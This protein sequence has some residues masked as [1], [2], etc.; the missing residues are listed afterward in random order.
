MPAGEDQGFEYPERLLRYPSALMF[1]LMREAFRLGQERSARATSDAEG[2]RFPHFATL[3]CLEEFGPASQR[4]IS[5][6]LRFDPSDLVAFVDWLEEAGLVVRRRDRRDRRRYAVELTAKGR[7]ALR[8]RAR[9]ADRLNEELFGSLEPDDLEA[10]R[11]LLLRA[12]RPRGRRAAD[13]AASGMR[14]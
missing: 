13:H 11:T 14:D 8:T 4:E 10:L 2:M 7:R 5:A 9:V 1:L 6:R 12:L 3:A